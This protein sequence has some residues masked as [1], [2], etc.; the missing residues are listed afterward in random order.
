MN[1]GCQRKAVPVW[2][3]RMRTTYG[4]S[5]VA[6]PEEHTILENMPTLYAQVVP[7]SVRCDN[8]VHTIIP[9]YYRIVACPVH[10]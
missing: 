10:K 4:W 9:T 8:V 3:R 7:Q 2:F 1:S 6:V 5:Y